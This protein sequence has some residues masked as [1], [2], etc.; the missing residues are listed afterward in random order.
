MVHRIRSSLCLLPALLAAP[1][2][3]AAEDGRW[4]FAPEPDPFTADAL[5]DL[6]S[7]NEK[8]AGEHG[9][10][11]VDAAGD[12]RDGAG[13]PLRFWAVNTGVHEGQPP[14]GSA[15]PPRDLDRHVRWLAKLGVNLVRSHQEF[16]GRKPSWNGGPLADQLATSDEDIERLWRLIAAAK[17]QGVYVCSSPYWAATLN[18]PASWG[19]AGKDKQNAQGLLFF[20]EQL[21]ADYKAWLKK[22]YATVNPHTGIALKDDP[23]LAII[24]LQNEDSLLFWTFGHIDPEQQRVLGRH[25][26]TWAGKKYGSAAQALSAWSGARPE[27]K[28]AIA[29]DPAGGVLGFYGLWQLTAGAPP[30]T[31]GMRKRLDDQLQFLSETM[32]DFNAQMVTYLRSEV[33]VKC[34][35]N[36]GNWKTADTGTLNDCERWSSSATDVLAVNRYYGGIHQGKSSGWAIVPGDRY[37]AITALADPSDLPV[38][39]KQVVGKPMMITESCWV[40]PAKYRAEGPALIAA[41]SSLSG[42]D[43]YFWFAFNFTT[44][45]PPISSNG[46]LK[47]SIGKW[48]SATPDQAGQFPAAALMFRKGYIRRGTPVIHEERPLT[49]LWQRTPA[50]INEGTSFDPNRDAGDAATPSMAASATHPLAFLVG[51]VEVVYGGD[52]A[53][54]R[55]APELATCNDLRH[56]TVRS[57]TGE[58]ALDYGKRVFT[59][60]APC[61]QGVVGF[62][63]EAGGE[64]T[65]STLQV[66]SK[67]A[68]AAVLAVALDGQPLASSKQVLI[69]VGTD[70]IPTGW[71]EKPVQIEVAHSTPR[72][73]FEITAVGTAPWQISDT[74]VTLTLRNAGLHTATRLDAGGYAAG[75]VAVTAATGGVTLELPRDALYTV[76]TP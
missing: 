76:L 2:C 12:F 14:A 48:V 18:I 15:H 50:V 70:S 37:T 6:R 17:Q 16:Y 26:A 19:I 28:N 47:P 38:N 39:L 43:A 23:A 66:R 40:P 8:V 35:I 27:D 10:V 58:L 57:N 33:G 54:T 25:F 21:Q 42:V 1:L 60:D 71:A 32:H 61:A 69:Q 36:A 20:N 7:L 41:Y 9:F 11:T 68:Y 73:G 46:F 74:H 44:W 24:Q 13:A 52:P 62:L 22:A 5:L 34:L 53:K 59:I 65:T 75:T 45:T 4:A 72:P 51:P 63:A 49:D 30:A 56:R 55:V 31:G 67:N 64:F 29:D 3:A